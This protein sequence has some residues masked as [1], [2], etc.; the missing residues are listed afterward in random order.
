MTYGF[1][2]MDRFTGLYGG[3][4]GGT[5]RRDA[6]LHAPA[7]RLGPTS[8]RC[9][10]ASSAASARRRSVTEPVYPILATT[11]NSINLFD[12][13]IQTPYVHQYSAGFQRSLGRDMAFEVRYVG[14][15]NM[16]AWTTE[17]WNAEETIFENGFLDEFK[18][19]A[20]ALELARGVSSLHV[21][22]PP[23]AEARE[24]EAAGMMLRAGRAVPLVERGLSRAST[25]FSPR[26]RT[27]S[28][29]R[30]GRSGA[31]SAK[32]ASRSGARSAREITREDWRFFTRCYTPHLPRAHLLALPQPRLLRAARRDAARARAARARGA[33]RQADRG[34]AQRV[35][36]RARSTAATGARSST[37]R[38][39]ISRPAT[40]RRSSSASSAASRRFEGG[41]QGEHKL[42]RGFLPETTWSA[43]WLAPPAVRRRGGAVPRARGAGRR[44]LRRRAGRAQPVPA[45]RQPSESADRRRQRTLARAGCVAARPRARGGSDRCALRRG[46][47]ACCARPLALIG[48]GVRR[49][50]DDGAALAVGT[51]MDDRAV[52]P[53]HGDRIRR[54]P[55][56]PRCVGP[57]DRCRPGA[58]PT[59]GSAGR[60]SRPLRDGRSSRPGASPAPAP[61]RV[62]AS[63]A[64]ARNASAS[65]TLGIASSPHRTSCPLQ[66]AAQNAGFFFAF[67]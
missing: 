6:Q 45:R 1:E 23:E 50:R 14:N 67:L 16:N 61:A 24:L 63:A 21:L 11:A 35:T 22:F 30:S 13:N 15:R 52:G 39:C 8:G 36:A 17:N 43:H 29:R 53:P 33:R 55:G 32:R 26:S 34:R 57:D 40:T 3:N 64:D 56:D 49:R 42:A 54:G 12:P 10:S 9:C 48:P 41:A 28:A 66:L 38:A 7:S 46:C 51:G 5:R 44:A 18:L 31:R 58:S 27:T 20:A 2:R 19:V 59:A 47:C 25:S 65:A 62:C 37:S 4:P 60:R